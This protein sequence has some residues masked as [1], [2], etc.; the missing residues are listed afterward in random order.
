M[1]GSVM[2]PSLA[3]H[4]FCH[5]LF[6]RKGI[7]ATPDTCVSAPT[8]S[9]GRVSVIACA[10][11]ERSLVIKVFTRSRVLRVPTSQIGS[12]HIKRR[13][14]RNCGR[15]SYSKPI[16]HECKGCFLSFLVVSESSVFQGSRIREP[17]LENVLNSQSQ[18]VHRE[19]HSLCFEFTIM[20]KLQPRLMAL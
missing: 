20:A 11:L 3:N 9:P 2:H 6:T 12:R 5:G 19:S 17:L 10:R 8:A 14:Y 1:T 4:A 16:S 13:L 7:K 18:F 15:N